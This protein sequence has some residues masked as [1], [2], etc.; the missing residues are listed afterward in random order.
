MAEDTRAFGK[1]QAAEMMDKLRKYKDGKTS[2]DMKATENQE[3]W[4]VRHWDVI[5]GETNEAKRAEHKVSVGSA[6]AINSLLN[7]HADIMDSF[8][9][10][11]VLPREADDEEE[12]RMLSSIVPVILEHNDYEG[13]YRQMGWDFTIDGAAITGVFWDNSKNDGL[14]D[15]TIS[16]VDVHNLMWRPGITDIQDSDAVFHVTLQD[17]EALKNAWPDSAEYIQPVSAM[18]MAT[19]I[20]DDNIDTSNMCELV[21]CYYKKFTYDPVMMDGDNNERVKVHEIPRTVVHLAIMVGDEVLWCSENEPGFENG[22]YDH[23]KYPFVVRRCFPIKDSAWGFG[24]LDIM[25]N[26]QKDID[27]LDQAI[28]KD[29]LQKANNRYWVKKNA[30][31]NKEAFADWSQEIIE[32]GT[33]DIREQVGLVQ[34]GNVP[35]TAMQHLERKID[36]LKETSGNRDFSQ[37]SAANG[38]TAASAIAALQEAGSKLSRDVNKEMYRG[39]REEYYL[40][41]ELIR[42]FY[43]QPRTFRIQD[44]QGNTQFAEYSNEGLQPRETMYPGGVIRHSKPIFDIEITAEKQSP[45]NRA[46]QNETA[47][48]LYSLGL[49][50]PENSLPAMV[51][52]Q[53]MEFEGKEQVIAN[54][55]QNSMIMQQLQ[56]AMMFIQQVAMMSPE[57]GAMA[58]QAG[59]LQPEQAQAMMQAQQ[60]RSGGGV[61]NQGT[62]E[63]RAAKTSTD[64]T[65]TAKARMRAANASNPT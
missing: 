36:E 60:P 13:V 15:I 21:N 4:R 30:A 58:M 20:H 10:P 59:L 34:T 19:Y 6:W 57:I 45:F 44:E 61:N 41:I 33:G 24:Y 37:G 42:Q 38:V 49:F 64:T 63:E 17:V 12:A 51:C 31:I 7:K 1:E 28:I 39:A 35:T 3:W 55:Q 43:D 14:G 16:N 54:I 47:K 52:L 65:L 53:M 8:P 11:N 23:G 9:K 22:Y 27:K 46:A 50:H 62:P 2:I 18:N 32:I 40:I 29:A 56:S 26:P 25:K 5:R 48:E